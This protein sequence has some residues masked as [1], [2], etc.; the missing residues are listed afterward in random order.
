MALS[1]NGSKCAIF[2]DID[3]P[4]EMA[5]DK[6]K[7]GPQIQ[8]FVKKKGAEKKIAQF[9]KFKGAVKMTILQK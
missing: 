5:V 2:N 8:G 4:F 9:L 1:Q 3:K 6:Q 7:R